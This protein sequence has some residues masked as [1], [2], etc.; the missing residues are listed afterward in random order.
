VNANLHLAPST[1]RLATL[2]APGGGLHERADKDRRL[3]SILAKLASRFDRCVIDCPPTIGLLTFNGLRACRE[4]LIPVETGFFALRGAEKQWQTIQ[5][6]IAHINRPI[7][8]HMLATLHNPNS[9]LARDILSAL[10]REFAGQIMPIVIEEHEALREAAS[11]GQPIVEYAPQSEARR[12]FEA[13]ADWLEDHIAAPAVQ[14]E[15]FAPADAAASAVADSVALTQPQRAPELSAAAAHGPVSAAVD[16]RHGE[17]AAELVRR[18]QSLARGETG[19]GETGPA[20]RS[21]NV[22]GS[23]ATD[24]ADHDGNC[25]DMAK[26]APSAAATVVPSIGPQRRLVEIEVEPRPVP[27]TGVMRTGPAQPSFA[28]PRASA[29]SIPP[30][31]EDTVGESIRLAILE[32]REEIHN[33]QPRQPQWLPPMPL[34]LPRP[35]HDQICEPKPSFFGV[36]SAP[37]EIVF[38]QPAGIGRTIAIAGDFNRWSPRAG[39]LRPVA[40]AGHLEL[41]VKVSPGRYQYRLVVDGRWQADPYNAM[42]ER[43]VHGEPN[44]VVVVPPRTAMSSTLAVEPLEMEKVP[45]Q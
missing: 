15:T 11:F 12:Q 28:L 44:S 1:T 45:F 41:R 29:V 32:I 9:N 8:C 23:F 13:L 17:R 20:I 3:E 30:P 27:S 26:L 34:T 39:A 22:S 16:T 42:T 31:R 43:N 4:T 18:V 37:D 40:G 35:R 14:V 19:A 7:A 25:A 24:D 5:R 38:L 33:A 2:E 10:Q 21:V 36:R 6:L